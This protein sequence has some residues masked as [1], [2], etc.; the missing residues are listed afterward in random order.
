[1]VDTQRATRADVAREAGVS[2]ATVDRVLNK[3]AGAHAQTVTR[4]AQ[5]VQ[6]LGYRP[7]PSAARMA[8]A[9]PHSICFVLPYGSNSF[10]DMLQ[11]EIA[12]NDTWMADHRVVART[13]DVDAFAPRKFAELL[14]TL[15]GRLRLFSGAGPSTGHSWPNAASHLSHRA[16]ALPR[17]GRRGWQSDI[18]RA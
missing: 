6:R 11:Q 16:N 2:L 7:D 9:R 17:T 14:A 4:V 13:V 12:G 18:E 8:R 3:R 10:V 1:M 5:A 15:K